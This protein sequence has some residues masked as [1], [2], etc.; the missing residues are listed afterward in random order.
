M[1]STRGI[2]VPEV[3][4][5][6]DRNPPPPPPPPTPPPL[7]NMIFV[8]GDYLFSP[9]VYNEFNAGDRST[10]G[11][12]GF[13]SEPTATTAAANAATTDQH[14]LCGRRLPLLPDGLQ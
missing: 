12:G 13:R 14:D 5:G 1:S 11:N 6:S 10:G 3:T 7:T 9:T 8:A 2:V 4:A